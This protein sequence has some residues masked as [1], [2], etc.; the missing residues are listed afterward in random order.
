M[1]NKADFE[2]FLSGMQELR[3]RT[4]R[5]QIDA[6]AFF[7]EWLRSTQIT[8]R[9][10]LPTAKTSVHFAFHTATVSYC[11]IVLGNFVHQLCI[12]LH[13]LFLEFCHLCTKVTRSLPLVYSPFDSL[14]LVFTKNSSASNPLFRFSEV[15]MSLA[16]LLGAIA[17]LQRVCLYVLQH[18]CVL[19]LGSQDNVHCVS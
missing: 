3:K 8:F 14:I 18:A 7:L 5:W 17:Q 2:I 10:S 4:L 19:S 6:A 1:L 12:N 16:F 13:I 9:G 11:R 15:I